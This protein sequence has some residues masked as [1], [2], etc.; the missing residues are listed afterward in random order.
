MQNYDLMQNVST[1]IL[2]T[3]FAPQVK[4]VFV[5]LIAFFCMS[6]ASGE[7][8]I[9]VVDAS[10]SPMGSPNPF[11]GQGGQPDSLFQTAPAD[12]GS[13]A[14]AP[15]SPNMNANEP[16]EPFSRLGPC[17]FCGDDGTP[18]MPMVDGTCPAITCD[19]TT[20]YR[21][22]EENDAVRCI[23]LGPPP[24]G[25]QTCVT[26]GE[27]PTQAT[28]CEPE[29]RTIG[30]PVANGGC[31]VLEGCEGET[32]PEQKPVAAGVSCRSGEKPEIQYVRMVTRES[33]RP[34]TWKEITVIGQTQDADPRNVID[35]G[36]VRIEVSSGAGSGNR[37]IDDDESTEWS[38]DTAMATFTLNLGAVYELGRINILVGSGHGPNTVHELLIAGP[39][40]DYRLVRVYRGPLSD[41]QWLRFGGV[42]YCDANKICQSAPD[43]DPFLYEGR[44]QIC[45]FGGDG[46]NTYCEIFV[47]RNADNT[48]QEKSCS[49]VCG[50]NS[51]CV[52]AYANDSVYK[53]RRR[54]NGNQDCDTPMKDF[55][56]RCAIL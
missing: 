3:R 32:P 51:Q 55:I 22:V 47:D 16:C 39:D 53:C 2:F 54:D 35:G 46:Q 38:P 5:T 34:V 12:A 26:L 11:P 31:Q 36:D 48:D 43:C 10:M 41:G 37:L 1:S 25:S 15:D 28:G 50:A 44:G 13:G 14:I 6:C 17:S 4:D 24:G 19:G 21:Q 29:E 9:S 23:A 8:P 49:D 42:G 56:C 27:C 18:F 7:P 30:N 40:K 45:D 20:T 33:D 52:G